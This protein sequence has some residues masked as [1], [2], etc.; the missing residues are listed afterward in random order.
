MNSKAHLC[1]L[2]LVFIF[3]EDLIWW[4][5]GSHVT[6]RNSGR[7]AVHPPAVS[8][9]RCQSLFRSFSPDGKKN[10]LKKRKKEKEK[11]EGFL[12][13]DAQRF[14]RQVSR[15]TSN[16]FPSYLCTSFNSNLVN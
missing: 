7:S 16:Q 4:V 11:K 6:L 14:S 10:V 5:S 15:T 9:S 1:I 8:V 12:G 13:T 3:C 2:F